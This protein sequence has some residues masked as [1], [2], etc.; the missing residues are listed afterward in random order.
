MANYVRFNDFLKLKPVE[1]SDKIKDYYSNI[2]PGQVIKPLRVRIAATHS[3]KITRNNGFYLPS[4][5]RAGVPSWTDQYN[6]PI[7]IHHDDTQDAIGRVVSARYVDI[8]AGVKASWDKKKADAY[9]SGELTFNDCYQFTVDC[10]L[11]DAALIDDPSYEGLGYIELLV[12][13]TD[14]DAI[15]KILDGRYL[16]GSTGASTNR[17]VCSIC[18]QDWADQDG[19]CEHRP[20]K[21]YDGQ[22]C[23]LIAGK[24]TYDEYSFVN[25]PADRHSK[26]IEININGV[27]DFVKID[28]ESQ[29]NEITMVVDNTTEE[30]HKMELQ[31]VV[32][33]LQVYKPAAK[34]ETIE[35]ILKKDI[36]LNP[37]FLDQTEDLIKQEFDKSYDE[38]K[39]FWGDKYTDIVGD[40]SWG[41]E[42]ASMMFSAI[43]EET[44]SVIVSAIT[45]ATLSA[46]KRKSLSSSTFCGPD[47]SFPVPDCAHVV[48]ARRLISR[49]KGPGNKDSILACVNRKA[50]RMGCDSKK[51]KVEDV[52]QFSPD[53]FDRYEDNELIQLLSGLKVVLTERGIN[54]VCNCAPQDDSVK[55]KAADLET[56][57]SATQEELK[58]AQDGLQLVQDQFIQSQTNLFQEK[59]ERLFVIKSLITDTYQRE[60]FEDEI[61]DKGAEIIDNMLTETLK[62]FDL[63]SIKDK[64]DS[65][66]TKQPNSQVEDPTLHQ[67]EV[68]PGQIAQNDKDEEIKRVAMNRYLELVRY[69]RKTATRYLEDMKKQGIL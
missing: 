50:K 9:L 46:E 52:G 18:K 32:K 31:D 26:V 40:D 51:D 39:E 1:I 61:K 8:S 63:N 35:S 6:K 28:E 24:L 65:G 64:L 17:A 25:K 66:I 57:L 10:V 27:Q 2:Q 19:P 12:D 37:A 53:Y 36:E 7:L 48:A 3:G 60:V 59:K 47:R 34:L 4:E 45:D 5:M 62:Q 43:K 55:T 29:F 23:V 38:V 30:S 49:Y 69:D 41:S 42:Y 56:K 14:P 68:K 33:L 20:G 16:T 58:V 11:K 15:Q 44:D 22:K 21:L 67:S 13:I 54:D